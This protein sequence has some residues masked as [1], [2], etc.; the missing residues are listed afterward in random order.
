MYLEHFALNVPDPTALTDWY[1]DH[2]GIRIVDQ[3][4][5]P[6]FTRF[7]ADK[8]GRI[9]VEVY[10][11]KNAPIPDYAKQDPLVFHLAFAVENI[12]E[13]KNRLV[14]VGATFVSEQK[15]DNGSS[16]VMLRDPWGI[17]LQLVQRAVP[18][19]E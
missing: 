1:K 17:P 18:L 16:L 8:T 14:G 7:L 3:K 19:G 11:N 2:C 15:T 10:G 9:M 13:T 5:D 6:P 12:E 4:D